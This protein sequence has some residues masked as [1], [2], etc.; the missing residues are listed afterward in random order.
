MLE[1]IPGSLYAIGAFVLALWLGDARIAYLCLL[2]LGASWQAM[3]PIL[4][5]RDFAWPFAV[6]LWVVV[7]LALGWKVF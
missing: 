6:G 7:G 2:A 5:I 4:R 1:L 3:S